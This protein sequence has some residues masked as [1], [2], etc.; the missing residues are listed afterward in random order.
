M[1]NIILSNYQQCPLPLKQYKLFTKYTE[2]SK[3]INY[4]NKKKYVKS[5]KRNLKST[6]S[7]QYM[8]TLIRQQTEILKRETNNKDK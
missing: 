4:K 5:N 2:S 3:Q 6:E 1:Q 7:K 8:E